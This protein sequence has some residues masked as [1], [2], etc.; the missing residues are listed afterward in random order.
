MAASTANNCCSGGH[1]PDCYPDDQFE[2]IEHLQ[3]HLV[4]CGATAWAYVLRACISY[5]ELWLSSQPM[6]LFDSSIEAVEHLQDHF[7][8]CGVTA[9]KVTPSMDVHRSLHLLCKCL[10]LATLLHQNGLTMTTPSR[11]SNIDDMASPVGP[12]PHTL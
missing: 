8:S 10:R 3:D 5:I 9:F 12:L 6:L 11:V 4:R 1:V 2:V 7:V